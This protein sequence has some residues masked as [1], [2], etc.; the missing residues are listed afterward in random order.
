MAGSR[1]RHKTGRALLK[2]PPKAGRKK[3]IRKIARQRPAVLGAGRSLKA[4][5]K[6]GRARSKA[7]RRPARR[8]ARKLP[9]ALMRRDGRRPPLRRAVRQKP[10]VLRRGHRERRK[11]ARKVLLKDRQKAGRSKA[12]LRNRVRRAGR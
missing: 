1:L 9:L 3:A 11:A 2:L 10:A 12:A 7:I 6:I 4:Q 5:R 8:I